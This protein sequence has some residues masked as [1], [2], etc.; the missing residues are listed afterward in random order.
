MQQL[1]RIELDPAVEGQLILDTFQGKFDVKDFVGSVSEKLITQSKTSSGRA[2]SR[3]KHLRCLT[4]FSAAFDPKPFIRTFEAAV[5]RLIAIR[6]DVQTK[7]EQ[8]EK[9]VRVLE[10]EV[11]EENG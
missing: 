10:R 2:A 9:S 6:K 11:F 4:P 5:D 8:L 1:D 3:F 7:T